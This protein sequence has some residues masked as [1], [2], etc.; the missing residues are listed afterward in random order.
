MFGPGFWEHP[1]HGGGRRRFKRGMLRWIVLQILEAGERHGYDLL[2]FF[3]MRG[4]SPGA[5]SIYPL[6]ASL[7][8]EGLVQG[9]DENGRRVYTIT[10]E[11]RRRLREDAPPWPNFEE[12]FATKE[13]P[14]NDEAQGAFDRLAAAWAQ[15]KQ[16]AKPDTME[17]IVDILKEARKEIY[18]ALADE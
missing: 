10:E 3:Q 5:G 12:V 16:V 8:A 15:A 9:R 1:R 11:G 17:H 2:S 7:E 13:H 14:V 6:L 4:W 18:S